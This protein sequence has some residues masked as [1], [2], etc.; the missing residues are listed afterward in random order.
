MLPDL[1]KSKGNFIKVYDDYLLNLSKKEI[2]FNDLGILILLSAQATFNKDLYKKTFTRLNSIY[3][4]LSKEINNIPDNLK[5]DDYF[6]A[7]KILEIGWENIEKVAFKKL[8]AL[9]DVQYNQLRTFKPRRNA[10]EKISSIYKKFDK[11]AFNFNKPFLRQERFKK[12]K[13]N[14]MDV[15]LFYNKFPF[16]PY[17]TLLVPEQEKNH[18]QFLR[19]R[20]HYYACD[21]IKSAEGFAIGYN[22]IGAYASV[23][24]LHFQLFIEKEKMPVCN[25]V[26]KHN[27]GKKEYP[28]KCFVFESKAASWKF[29]SMLHENNIPYNIL[30][31]KEK[32]YI[33]PVNFQ[34]MHKK[35]I[36]P[37]GFAWIEFSGSF[38]N[39]AKRDFD[40][41]TERQILREFS[42]NKFTKKLTLK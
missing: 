34:K 5:N 35:T 2:S 28:A 23:N 36:F 25:P 11:N 41:L 31:T 40:K 42:M 8:N 15:S 37:L 26:W 39:V 1:F 22:S 24:H 38:I 14:G 6:V 9:W 20:F 4:K 29:I 30:Y 27:G 3:K 16:V 21:L 19:R 7:L 12:C 10:V 33:F 18:P 17:H 32:I 13:C